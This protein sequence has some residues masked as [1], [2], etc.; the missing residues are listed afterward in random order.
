M[1]ICEHLT[2]S[3]KRF[4]D[5]VAIVFEGYSFTYG[6]LDELSAKAALL[7]SEGGVNRGDRVAICLPNIPAFVIWYYASLRIGAIAVSI[8]TRLAEKEVAFIVSDC[9]AT[10]FIAEAMALS[11]YMEHLP[12]CVTETFGVSRLFDRCN[13]KELER[14]PIAETLKWSDAKPDEAAV[15]LYTSG[16]TG[17]AK[18]ATLSHNNVRSNVLEFN[19]L[20]DM[21]PDDRI[22]LA[23]PLFHCFGQNA[24]LN[25]ALNAGAT[26]VLQC[27]FDL[28]ESIRL[29]REQEVTQL[30]GVPTMFQLL[31][32]SCENEDLSSVRYCFSAAAKLP[33]QVSSSWLEKFGQPI[34][35]GYGLTETSPFASYNHHKQYLMG[36]VGAPI[37]QVEMKIVDIDTGENCPPGEL[38]EIAIRGPNVMLGYWNRKEETAEVIRDGWLHSGDIGRVDDRGYFYILDRIKDMMVVGGLKVYPAEVERILL[39]HESVSQAAVVGLPEDVFGEQVVA[40]V[41]MPTEASADFDRLRETLRKHCRDNLASYKVPKHFVPLEEMPRNP[42]GKVL[43]TKLR[44]YDLSGEK[45][46][47]GTSADELAVP[48]PALSSSTPEP[49]LWNN[50]RRSYPTNRPQVATEFVQELIQKLSGEEHRLEP[51]TRFLEVGLDSLMIIEM[52]SRIQAEVG[53]RCDLPVTLL[54]DCPRICDLA[55]FLIQTYEAHEEPSAQFNNAARQAVSAPAH[56]FGKM[57]QEINAM[58]EDEALEALM[59]ELGSS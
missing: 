21:R 38:G 56:D 28:N 47:N 10:A 7:L 33:V 59:R 57:R 32:E 34:Y 55:E 27:G 50:L 41:V 44:E 3:A 31:K 12:D 16:T 51:G 43:K 20:C 42:A 45:S 48:L 5:K 8:S 23:L 58:S 36:S 40:F 17:F 4:P 22:L 52:S 14:A 53:S 35:E 19:R 6:Q 18:G 46:T 49:T 26:I 2:N 54:F 39:D 11:R 1:N 13:G 25:S 30:Y 37:D 29:I 15:I 24:L 9:E